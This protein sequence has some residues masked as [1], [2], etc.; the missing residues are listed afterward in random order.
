MKIDFTLTIYYELLK[1][2]LKK[3]YKTYTMRQY[4]LE[5]NIDGRF[6]IFR[7]DV[8]KLPENSLAIAKIESE[9]GIK[10][11]YYFRTSNKSYNKKIINE[12]SKLGHEIGYHYENMDT[13]NGDFE[14][15]WIDFKDSLNKLRELATIDTICMHGS[16]L[17]KHDNRSLWEKYDY[18]DQ[19]IIGEPY[20]D[21]DFNK[22]E[23][24]TD[25]GRRWDGESVSIRDKIQSGNK[26]TVRSTHNLIE[27]IN[28]DSFPDRVMITTHPQRWTN[29]VFPWIVE[30]ILQNGKNIIKGIMVSKHAN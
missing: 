1:I 16:P 21:I 19:G 29:K 3:Q 6:I 2:I 28:K 27:L 10:S 26:I 22:I 30:Y 13:C 9:L 18:K 11:T 14:K 23:Y 8:D 17:S 15:A 20:F 5:K 4:L 12:I 7:H 24:L 25:T